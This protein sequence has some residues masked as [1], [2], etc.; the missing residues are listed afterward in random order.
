[1]VARPGQVQK[2][3]SEL[4][5]RI[6]FVIIGLLV[7]RLGSYIPV[8]GVNADVLREM[9]NSQSGNVMGMF[10]MFSGGA[11]ERASILALGIMPYISASIIIQLMSVMVPQLAELKKE[12][13]SGRRTLTKYTRWGTLLL[14]LVQASGIAYGLPRMM[15]G[16]VDNP[17]FQF[18]VV[19]T[20]S[21]TTGPPDL[22]PEKP[23]CRSRS[24]S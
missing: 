18:Y 23:V 11:L 16:L 2:E 14:G 20:L 19:A 17:S 13:E 5:Q 9:F 24:N 6:W 4:K 15:P 21:L 3:T 7:F 1:M 12:G 8:P 22:P 10:N